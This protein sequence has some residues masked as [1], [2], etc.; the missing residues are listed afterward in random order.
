MTQAA[1][2]SELDERVPGR[3]WTALDWLTDTHLTGRLTE[4]GLPLTCPLLA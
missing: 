3:R 2:G 1:A 4:R